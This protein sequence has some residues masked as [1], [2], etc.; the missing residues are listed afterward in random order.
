MSYFK[1]LFLYLFIDIIYDDK[2]Y[3]NSSLGQGLRRLDWIKSVLTITD[4]Y[5]PLIK[6]YF[7]ITQ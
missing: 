2:L 5:K 3:Y 1:S 7:S 6:I 4:M